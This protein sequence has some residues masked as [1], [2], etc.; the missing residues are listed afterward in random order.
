[1]L[2]P[3]DTHTS[4]PPLS[5][6]FLLSQSL[7]PTLLKGTV[8]GWGG[9][10]GYVCLMVYGREE[11]RKLWVKKTKNDLEKRKRGI[12]SESV[13]IYVYLGVFVCVAV[14]A[15]VL[16][17]HSRCLSF[18]RSSPAS[19]NR[20]LCALQFL[21]G[22][23]LFPFFSLHPPFQLRSSTP[24]CDCVRMSLHLS[25]SHIRMQH[26]YFRVIH[27]N[28]DHSH[29]RYTEMVIALWHLICHPSLL[30]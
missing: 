29:E 22:L 14:S 6:S 17:V 4:L 16:Q 18:F 1:M 26:H 20:S 12:S 27:F 13:S 9:F 10:L 25:N 7:A 3:T 21:R 28:V 30:H 15:V 24:S 19:I 11:E 2:S 23:V 5:R 8:L